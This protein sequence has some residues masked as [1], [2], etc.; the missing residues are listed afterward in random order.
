[1]NCA[2]AR[3]RAKAVFFGAPRPPARQR[4]KRGQ[5]A[6]PPPPSYHDPFSPQ[7]H[8]HTPSSFPPQGN[9]HHQKAQHQKQSTRARTKREGGLP[10]RAAPPEAPPGPT[11]S[12]RPACPSSSS[13]SF[14]RDFIERLFLFKPIHHQNESLVTQT[15]A[16]ENNKP[17]KPPKRPRAAAAPA[18]AAAA[19]DLAAAAVALSRALARSLARRLGEMPCFLVPSSV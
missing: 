6:P 18:A 12:I 19:Y 8:T 2:R 1:M 15:R 4:G 3:A 17:K 7:T 14:L 13:S 9:Q 11:S 16:G 10:R 5:H